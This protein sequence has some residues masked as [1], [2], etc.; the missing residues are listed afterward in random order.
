[1][2][3]FI[4]LLCLFDLGLADLS[5]RSD[6]ELIIG[7]LQFFSFNSWASAF[8]VTVAEGLAGKEK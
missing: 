1:M 3:F 5:A 2:P 4:I 6:D 8:V 7:V